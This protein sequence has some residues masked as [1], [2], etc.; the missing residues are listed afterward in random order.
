MKPEVNVPARVKLRARREDN[1][2][3]QQGAALGDPLFPIVFKNGAGNRS[4]WPGNGPRLVESTPTER[5]TRGLDP[6]KS[7][8]PDLRT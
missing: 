3:S 8:L 2:W 7:G 4:L 6:R 1:R 5:V